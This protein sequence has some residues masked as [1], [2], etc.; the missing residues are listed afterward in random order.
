MRNKILNIVMIFATLCSMLNV[1]AK[2]VTVTN[3]DEE[4]GKVSGSISESFDDFA[5]ATTPGRDTDYYQPEGWYLAHRWNTQTNGFLRPA[6]DAEKGAV[7]QVGMLGNDG[8][9]SHAY[10]PLN[11]K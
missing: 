11:K 4:T 5:T 6:T 9:S 2:P 1:F 7:M 3:T 10:L 8:G